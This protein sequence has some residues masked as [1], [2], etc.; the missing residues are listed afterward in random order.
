M[1]K[2]VLSII[3][4]RPEALTKYNKIEFKMN[5]I[6]KQS[7]VFL[8]ILN[9]FACNISVVPDASSYKPTTIREF[10]YKIPL[11]DNST[12]DYSGSFNGKVFNRKGEAVEG[13]SV[14]AKTIDDDINWTS[15]TKLT[16]KEGKYSISKAPIGVRIAITIT[17]DN[18]FK[19]RTEILETGKALKDNP[20]IN[21]FDFDKYYT[22]DTTMFRVYLYD[23]NKNK[24]NSGSVKFE[25][26]DPNF[27]YVK[28]FPV[29]SE[30]IIYT[31]S[32]EP[33]PI[34]TKFKL[35]A[36]ANNKEIEK[37]VQTEQSKLYTNVEFVM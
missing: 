27:E 34:N 24:I 22:L 13:V 37:V 6:L 30:N 2:Q 10:L 23:E 11:F 35:T 7:F 3:K 32:T 19:T 16:D 5:K 33:L 9:T 18:I 17:K 1:L 4:L 28:E 21:T 8:L 25:S 36:K 14:S 20:L 29:K 26:L 31:P 12:I 15:E